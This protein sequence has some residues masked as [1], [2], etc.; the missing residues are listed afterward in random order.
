MSERYTK[1]VA[2]VMTSEPENSSPYGTRNK[3]RKLNEM[4]TPQTI[5]QHPQSFQT[6]PSHQISQQS[7]QNQYTAR[8]PMF[9]RNLDKALKSILSENPKLRNS[10]AGGT[11]VT[12]IEVTP[13]VEDETSSVVLP[14]PENG[15]TPSASLSSQSREETPSSYTEGIVETPAFIIRYE[16][17][18]ETGKI[19]AQMRDEAKELLREW[20][21]EWKA[22]DKKVRQLKR[23]IKSQNAANGDR[24][25]GEAKSR[26]RSRGRSKRSVSRAPAVLIQETV[27][28][29]KR[30]ENDENELG[31]LSES[32]SRSSGRRDSLT[33]TG[34]N[35]LTGS[36]WDIPS[37][38]TGR[39]NRR[40]SKV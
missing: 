18:R 1:S 10:Q 40:K 31:P 17:E 7:S 5:P 4:V 15:R 8:S 32:R 34:P 3:R 28:S 33:G 22:E 38:G 14:V 11:T 29:L 39:A 23:K 19:S 21:M 2:A 25:P 6:T 9:S 24:H 30:I 36:Y 20:G 12:S 27:E 16:K 26:G 35:G 37:D 13:S